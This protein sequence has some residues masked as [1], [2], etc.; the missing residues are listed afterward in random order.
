MATDKPW[1]G[2]A[3]RFKDAAEYCRACLVNE[4]TGPSENW[5]KDKCHLPVREPGGAVNVNGLHAAAAALA[6]ARGG[7]KIPPA[8]KA[9]AA[10][11]LRGLYRQ[12]GED[13]PDSLRNMGK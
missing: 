5:T 1:D 2:S 9:K 3:A 13:I 11:K 7:V 4:N 6:G 8:E 10:R 12:A